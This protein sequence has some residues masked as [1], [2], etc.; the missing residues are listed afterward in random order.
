G[1][2]NEGVTILAPVTGNYVVQVS[3]YNGAA[4][5]HPYSLQAAMEA[6]EPIPSCPATP[7]TLPAVPA[8]QVGTLPA[9]VA[10]TA[11]TLILVN[12]SRLYA[13]Y[14]DAQVATLMN[15]LQTFASNATVKGAVVKV[16]GS[17]AV[18]A[19]YSAWDADPC[20]VDLA[21]DVVRKV[22]AA[23]DG[24]VDL[25]A[26][27][28]KHM[29]VVGNDDVMPSARIPDLTQSANERNYADAVRIANGSRAPASA[30]AAGNV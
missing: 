23:V 22:N 21:N 4:S 11:E 26:G 9:S 3:G 13:I 18:R 14:D 6:G 1:G 10:S 30:L 24:F 29:V 12:Q 16:D 20:S 15:R 25:R 2:F 17:S 5:S 7:R 28:I 27:R 19:A 8:N